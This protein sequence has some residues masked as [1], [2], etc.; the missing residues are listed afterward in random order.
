M[1]SFLTPSAENGTFYVPHYAHWQHFLTTLDSITN[2]RDIRKGFKLL[3]VSSLV[4]ALNQ[5]TPPPPIPACPGSKTAASENTAR[6]F[7][8]ARHL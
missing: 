6:V 1:Q 7:Y 8:I 4:K 5:G 3:N 2:V